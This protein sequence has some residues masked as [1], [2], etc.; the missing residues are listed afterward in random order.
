MPIR[1]RKTFTI[2]PGVRVN[3]S[4]GG[5][6][7]TVGKKGFHLN[8]GK[9]GVRE[10]VGLPGSGFSETNYL[11]KNDSKDDNEKKET[12]KEER[13]SE[14]DEKN[15]RRSRRGAPDRGSSP[16]GFF[17]FVLIALF[18]IYFG[19]SALGLLPPHFLSDL[20][21]ALAHLAKQARL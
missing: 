5:T 14:S 10:T 6:S 11:F 19:A 9:H 8:F 4:K 2:F 7:I 1:F 20:F 18:F 13:I 16:W 17:A 3:V 15:R 12:R 21:Q